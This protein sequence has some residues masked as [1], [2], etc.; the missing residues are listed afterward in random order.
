MISEQMEHL[1]E[2]N[3]YIKVPS[4]LPEFTFYYRQ[5]HQGTI[6]VHVIDYRQDVYISEDQYAHLKQKITEYIYAK[7]EQEVHLLSLIL[8]NDMEKAKR[9]CVSDSF[10]W[11]IDTGSNRLIIHENQVDDFYGWKG[12]LEEFLLHPDEIDEDRIT[13]VDGRNNM[14]SAYERDAQTPQGFGFG[15]NWD[16]AWL[17]KLPWVNI[18]L[19]VVNVIVFI[20]CTF[21]G[22]V[23]YNKGALGVMMIIEDQSYYRMIT[24]MFL[25]ADTGHLFSNMIVLY[26]AGEIVEKKL[27]HVPY[28]LL[29]F[30]SGI[31]GGVLSMGYELLSGDYISSVGASGAVF[32]VEGALLMLVILHHGKLESVTFGKLAFVIAF[33]LYCGFTSSDIN[34]AA[35]I[36]GVLMGFALAA[37][38]QMLGP[39]IR[40][41]KDRDFDEN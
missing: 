7:G 19:I 34:N 30:L 11:M 6:V 38:F 15:K 4:N 39:Y 24:S 17:K 21:T 2:I 40:T 37:V 22:R 10:C 31:A 13:G 14:R 5:E 27:G 41:G 1:F 29:Y 12:I 23:L 36:G 9:L 18:C 20:I 28:T 3:G 33:S 16:G 32:G 35:H 8:S 25:H 26:Y